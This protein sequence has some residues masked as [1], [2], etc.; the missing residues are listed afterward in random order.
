MGRGSNASGK[1]TIAKDLIALSS[2]IYEYRW[3]HALYDGDTGHYPKV[4]VTVLNDIH[5]AC[6]GSYPE[7]KKM[8][9]CDTFDSVYQTKQ[10]IADTLNNHR[11]G[12]RGI[13][14]E[15]MVISTI[16]TTF[17]DY[18]I[19]LKYFQ[20]DPYFVIMAAGIEGCLKRIVQRGTMKPNLNIENV[21]NKC[22]LNMKIAKKFELWGGIPVRYMYVDNIARED[23]LMEFFH[24][25]GEE[26][27]WHSIQ[28][29]KQVKRLI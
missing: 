8:G 5:W 9:G 24:V 25:V 4:Y 28:R 21:R 6:I 10:A 19:D 11:D 26:H 13:Y 23:M 22:E 20:V 27:S 3:T 7:D 2:D 1:T 29:A 16:A 12:L 18:M 14:Y 17:Y 15:G